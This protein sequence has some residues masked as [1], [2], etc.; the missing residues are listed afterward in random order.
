MNAFGTQNPGPS[1]PLLGHPWQGPRMCAG[2]GP[3]SDAPAHPPA[4]PARQAQDASG[5]D[6]AGEGIN[7]HP[8]PEV[9]QVGSGDWEGTLLGVIGGPKK[10]WHFATKNREGSPPVRYQRGPLPILRG[11]TH[12]ARWLPNFKGKNPGL[13][14][15]SLGK[16]VGQQ[17]EAPNAAA[18][19]CMP[20]PQPRVWQGRRPGRTPG[21]GGVG[22]PRP[23]TRSRAEASD[24]Q[25]RQQRRPGALLGAAVGPQLHPQ[26]VQVGGPVGVRPPQRRAGQ[27]MA[28]LNSLCG[29]HAHR[30]IS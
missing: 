10:S 25:G 13:D 7:S 19:H 26:P 15:H 17:A 16:A 3:R 24:G 11:K 2:S 23:R 27:P 28:G 8:P 30:G 4:P 22:P 9:A 29:R 6:Q 1:A 5:Q 18:A 12:S 14:P 20:P 21:W